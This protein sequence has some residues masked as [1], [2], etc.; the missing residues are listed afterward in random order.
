MYSQVSAIS[1]ISLDQFRPIAD[2]DDDVAQ[3]EA[4]QSDNDLF[5][6]R[7]LADWQQWLW[8]GVS[9]RT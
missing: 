3:I 2:S 8:D 1:E 7:M 4:L 6:D 5:K 9:E